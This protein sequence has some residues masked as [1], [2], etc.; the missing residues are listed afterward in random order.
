MYTFHTQQDEPKTRQRR[1]SGII[2]QSITARH[3]LSFSPTI[4]II[5]IVVV[6]VIIIFAMT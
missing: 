6:V 3:F 2:N 5:I 1:T 4:I